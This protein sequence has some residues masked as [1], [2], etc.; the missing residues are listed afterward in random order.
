MWLWILVVLALIPIY[1]V[2]VRHDIEAHRIETAE[3]KAATRDMEM[4]KHTKQ[5]ITQ[6]YRN[7]RAM[8]REASQKR[9]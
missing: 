6:D 7:A 8:I 3:W 4:A 5:Q 2:M 1:T 9:P